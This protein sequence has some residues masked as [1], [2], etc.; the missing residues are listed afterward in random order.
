VKVVPTPASRSGSRSITTSSGVRL[1]A[2]VRP[3]REPARPAPAT[4]IPRLV[5]IQRSH[6]LA[7]QPVI[8]TG[9]TSRPP[10]QRTRPDMPASAG[11]FFQILRRFYPS[12]AIS[13]TFVS[14]EFNGVTLDNNGNVRPLIPRSFSSLSQAEEENGQSR[15][16]LG[17]RRS[18]TRSSIL[19]VTS[20][21]TT[22][23]RA[24]A[25]RFCLCPNML[26][27]PIRCAPLR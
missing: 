20:C 2:S 3:T 7:H 9:Q 5:E 25:Y 8:S 17:R 10:S 15:I 16:Y 22:S 11:P 14:D 12:D 21:C 23:E 4:A 6:R 27:P 26:R 18:A 19:T 1:P 24:T 13:F